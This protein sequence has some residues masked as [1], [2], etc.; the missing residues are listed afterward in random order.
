MI[1]EYQHNG[2]MSNSLMAKSLHTIYWDCT[3]HTIIHFSNCLSSSILW[4][5]PS[6]RL[7]CHSEESGKNRISNEKVCFFSKGGGNKSR[8]VWKNLNTKC[9][10]LHGFHRG[11]LS[12]SDCSW[13]KQ[14]SLVLGCACDE[15]ILLA[16]EVE[17]A[18]VG[19]SLVTSL[20]VQI[21]NKKKNN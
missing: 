8:L 21:H 13:Q 6:G 12:V 19:F 17:E 9:I 14:V 15:G 5:Q 1:V 11:S 4:P 18:P 10:C 2:E 20:V 16:D 3:I 7:F